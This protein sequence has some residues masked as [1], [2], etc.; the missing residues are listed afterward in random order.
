MIKVVEMVNRRAG[1]DVEAFQAHWLSTHGPLVARLPGLRRYVQSHTRL[2]G[3]RRGN[4]AFDGIAELWFDDKAA[5]AAIASTPEFAAA[6]NDEPNFIETNRL[7]ELVVDDFVAKD[8]PTHDGGIK[9]V[10]FVHLLSSLGPREAHRYWR[11][12]HA[13]IVAGLPGLRR[14]VQ[15]HTRMG[16]YDRPEPPAFD[17]L[18]ITWWDNVD[19]M[20]ASAASPA[21]ASIRADEPNFLDGEPTT[22]LTTEHVIVG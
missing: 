12:H 9:S 17:G 3:Y 1:L 22:I 11:E 18:A 4:V 20:R 10:A 15:S 21:Y 16:A 8:G 14:Y 19:A 6:K 5:L 7:I 2:G 13:R